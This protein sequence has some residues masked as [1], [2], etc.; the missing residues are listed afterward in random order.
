[1]EIWQGLWIDA[2]TR[3]VNKI[4]QEFAPIIERKHLKILES[5]INKENINDLISSQIK[6]EEID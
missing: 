1:M 5:F 4:K 2:S 3:S 6:A